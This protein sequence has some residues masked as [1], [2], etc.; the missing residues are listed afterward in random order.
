MSDSYIKNLS[1]QVLKQVNVFKQS[2]CKSLIINVLSF[3]NFNWSRNA[4]YD[5]LLLYI[6]ILK[7]VQLINE[8]CLA[9]ANEKLVW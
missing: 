7:C 9:L 2:V 8:I 3:C 1:K 6:S 4:N 5:F